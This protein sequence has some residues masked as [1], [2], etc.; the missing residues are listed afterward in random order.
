MLAVLALSALVACGDSSFTVV[1][2][3][4]S[5]TIYLVI[6]GNADDVQQLRNDYASQSGGGQIVDG[7]QHSGNL[8]CEHD[9]TKNGHKLHFALYGSGLSTDQ[10]QQIFASF[11]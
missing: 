7:D 11:P 1:G 5:G 4:S 10:C 6:T 8:I 3:T 9:T 2:S